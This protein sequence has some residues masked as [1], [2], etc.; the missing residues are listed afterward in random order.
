ML[1]WDYQ[2]RQVHLTM[3]GYI[4]K[5]L[6]LFQHDVQGNKNA[7]YPNAMIKY[8]SKKQCAQQESTAPPLNATGKK[9][10]QQICG[11]FLFLGPAVNIT[12]LCLI[13][14]LAAQLS[15][16]IKDTM[17]YAKQFLDYHRVRGIPNLQRK[18]YETSGTQQCKLP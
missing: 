1:D 10:I 14:A 11:K 18:Q 7:P 5:A 6:K 3:P 8:R 9:F 12:L 4:N 2:R 13:S 16:P 15:N 17:Q